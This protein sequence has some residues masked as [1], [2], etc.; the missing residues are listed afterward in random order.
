MAILFLK[1]RVRGDAMT[2]DLFDQ[3]V[4]VEGYTTKQGTYV[5]PHARRVKKR[6]AAFPKKERHPRPEPPKENAAIPKQE[7][8][9]A[10]PVPAAA[11]FAPTHRTSTGEPVRP[12]EEDGIAQ[13]NTWEN[14]QGEIIEDEHAVP[15]SEEPDKKPS[16][17]SPKPKPAVLPAVVPTAVQSDP[18]PEAR[19]EYAEDADEAARQQ[20]ALW[21][22][23]ANR[24]RSAADKVIEKADEEISRDRL[25]N[26]H[27]RA[28]MAANA[29]RRAE[30]ERALGVTMRNLADAIESGQSNYLTGVTQKTHVETLE[31]ILQ[32]AMWDRDRGLSSSEREKREGR[33][34]EPEDIEFASLPELTLFGNIA[35]SY[36]ND[37]DRP[38]SK[39]LAIMLRQRSYAAGSEGMVRLTEEEASQ[40]VAA[41]KKGSHD[42]WHLDMTLKRIKRLSAMGIKDNQ[43]LRL[44]LT[45]YAMF[46]AGARNPDP[47]K[48][49]ERALIGTKIPG[50]FPTPK[51]ITGRMVEMAGI[52]PGMKVLEPS[53]GKGDIAD[54][55]RQAG[56]APD[57]VEVNSTLRTILE[58]K[59][60]SLAGFDFMEIEPKAVYDAVVMNPPFENGQ[61]MEHVRHAWDFVRPGGRLVAIMSEGTFFRSDRKARDFS[62]WLE[63]VG[64]EAEQ[65]PQGSFLESDRS[66]GVNTRLVMIEKPAGAEPQARETMEVEHAENKYDLAEALRD[67]P[68]SPKTREL[69]RRVAETEETLSDEEGPKEGDTKTEDGV[70]YVLRDG[71]WHR[72]TPEETADTPPPVEEVADP[73]KGLEQLRATIQE[74]GGREKAA[75]MMKRASRDAMGKARAEGIITK[76]QQSLGLTR[77]QVLAEFGLRETS[78][79]VTRVPKKKKDAEPASDAGGDFSDMDPDSPNYRFRDTGHIPG[80]RKE[81]AAN[82]VKAAGARGE[83]Q[84]F[85]SI[86]WEELEQNPRQAKEV[87]TKSN[88][89]GTVDW[90][91]LKSGGM[92]PG[93]GFLLDRVYAA[94]APEPS[95]DSPQAR[96][97]YTL[98]LETLRARLEVCKTPDDVTNVL[99]ELRDEYDGAILNDVEKAAYEEIGAISAGLYQKRSEY[100]KQ[101]DEIAGRSNLA[102]S[103]VTSLKWE[104]DKRLRRGWKPDP[105]LAAKIAAAQVEADARHA[106]VMEFKEKNPQMESKK[107][108]LGNGWTSY[109]SDLEFEIRKIRNAQELIVEK[110]KL[111]NKVENPLH[112]AWTLMGDRFINVLKYRSFKGSDAF[113]KHVATAKGGKIRDW[114]WMEKEVKRGPRTTK[115]SVRFQLK[116]AEKYDRV[117]GRPVKADS[118]ATLKAMFGLRDV[119]S[120]NWVLRDV[121][122]AKFHV[123]QCSAAFADLADLIGV[124]DSFLSMNGRL[125]MAFGA[126]GRGAAGWSDSAPRAHYEPVQRVINLTKM[127]GGGT[128]AHE[129]FHC[130]DNLLKEASGGG[131][132]D[133]GDYVTENMGIVSDPDLQAA[134]TGLMRAI[135]D[136]PHR[137]TTRIAYSAADYATAKHNLERPVNPVSKGVRA[138]GNLE[139]ALDHID[140]Y[141]SGRE[142]KKSKKLHDRWRLLAAAWY[143][144]KPG[145]GEAHAKSGAP[146]SSFAMEAVILDEGR[147][148]RNFSKRHEMAA[149]AFQSWCE[150]RLEEQGRQNDYLSYAAD[151]KHYFDPFTGIQLRPYPE[152][153]ERTRINAAFDKFFEVLRDKQ[154]I[155][156]AF[157]V[158]MG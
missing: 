40:I 33:P 103:K 90:D 73:N 149:R 63:S 104:Q 118:T 127:G 124:P 80:S 77:D 15:Y 93:T 126:R 139:A 100:R 154:S 55:V 20:I 92:E 26:T 145:G 156:K 133:V 83:Q 30:K 95:E 125:A 39:K 105:G 70:T 101:Y 34:A 74:M 1:A 79:Q 54:A 43:S 106:E 3:T 32:R 58:S 137:F 10:K 140:S 119:Q 138:A 12:Y 5:P 72:E 87:I 144:G 19:T 8:K 94:I 14:A 112:R 129:W 102:S 91:A 41:M 151:N 111:R 96:K 143:D 47:I 62:E 117:G 52:E 67:E 65:L 29:I 152:G 84:T 75:E 114:S 122:A 2:G 53:A 24:L 25:A 136:G 66:T 44:A 68:D 59:G 11:G 120:G 18:E 82:E 64:G 116:V 89:F 4:Q 99:N 76:F 7:E 130:L 42:P 51:T 71:R 146:V 28:G 81:D 153:E 31:S 57:V 115:E 157:S 158:L 36:A 113:A 49:A 38:G 22:A 17:V 78:K 110:A 23:H 48:E 88:L 131:P 13:D 134:A 135:M 108:D 56:V 69:I 147:H 86:R 128:L 37:I 46:R 155:L 85:T 60:Y 121:N 9:P 50:Y 107:R 148:G 141:F 97:D 123:E 16:P 35:S 109:D 45:E 61:D 150:D 132:S 142:D 21:V 27:R 98:G 6:I